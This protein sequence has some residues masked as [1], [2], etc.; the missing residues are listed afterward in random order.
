M[1]RDTLGI[2]AE[3]ETRSLGDGR[4]SDGCFG[5]LLFCGHVGPL[6]IGHLSK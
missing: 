1:P 4:A 6:W 3:H 2:L 5:S